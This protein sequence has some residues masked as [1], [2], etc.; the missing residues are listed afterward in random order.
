MNIRRHALTAALGVLFGI[1]SWIGF[2]VYAPSGRAQQFPKAVL[3]SPRI[4]YAVLSNLTTVEVNG[5]TVATAWIRYLKSD[6]AEAVG[7]NASANPSSDFPKDDA[8]LRRWIA[9]TSSEEDVALG[10][11][12]LSASALAA[13]LQAQ[14]RRE[15]LAK[16]IVKLGAEGYELISP[17]A[18]NESPFGVT[19]R[20]AGA[21]AATITSQ[22]FPLY[23]K[24]TG[25]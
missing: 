2:S 19:P 13:E 14:A 3:Q 9:A 21:P 11:A 12:N 7:V 18:R 4:Q 25:S 23:F 8:A 5:K 22:P 15:A 16:A 10:A 6:G 20:L 1:A 24:R 17:D